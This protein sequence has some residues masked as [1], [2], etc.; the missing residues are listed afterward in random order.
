MRQIRRIILAVEDTSGVSMGFHDRRSFL[1]P[2]IQ[3]LEIR[4]PALWRCQTNLI[5]PELLGKMRGFGDSLR[6]RVRKIA[7]YGHMRLKERG[8]VCSAQRGD[9]GG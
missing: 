4:V 8:F 2:Q 3:T 9:G 7:Q 5:G 6:L 1:H